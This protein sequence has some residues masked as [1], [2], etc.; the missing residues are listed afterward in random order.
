MSIEDELRNLC[1]DEKLT[2]G[3]PCSGLEEA[4]RLKIQSLSNGYDL[5]MGLTGDTPSYGEKKIVQRRINDVNGS[6]VL[7]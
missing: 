2:L 6:S 3:Q 7:R 5:E 4:V 1:N